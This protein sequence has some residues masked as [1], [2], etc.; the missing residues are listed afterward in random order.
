MKIFQKPV[1][2]QTDEND[3]VSSQVRTSYAHMDRDAVL[4]AFHSRGEGLSER[5]AYRRFDQYGPNAIAQEKRQSVLSR[6]WSNLTNPLVVMLALIGVVS[7]FTNDVRATVIIFVMLVIGVALRFFQELRADHAAEALRA[8]VRNTATVVRAGHE[9]EVALEFL[10]PGDVIRLSAGDM[11]PADVRILEAKDLFVNQSALTGESMPVEKKTLLETVLSSV[12]SNSLAL[13]NL[14][15]MGSNVVSGSAVAVVLVTGKNTYFGTLSAHITHARE[16]TSFDKGVDQLT[17]FIIRVIAVTV[18]L[19]FLINGWVRHDWV[20]AFLFALAVAVGLTPEML[21]MI[22]SVNLAKG[23]LKLAKKKI[24]V[25]RLNSIQNFGAMDVLCTDKTGTLTQGKIVLERHLDVN[26]DS[27][28]Q[29]LHYGY[30]NSYHHTGLKN[31]LDEAILDH[32]ELEER[33]KAKARYRKID[34]VPFDFVRRR[35]SVIV[36]DETGLNTLICKGAVEEIINQCN[37][38]EVN[39]RIEA[40]SDVCAEES[41]AL[42]NQLNADGFRVIALSYKQMPGASDALVYSV[43]DESDLILLGF[44]AFL[45]PPKETAAE[46]LQLLRGLDV[47]VKIL[48]GDNEIVTSYICR[49]VGIPVESVMLGPMIESMSD[50]ELAIAVKRTSVFARLAPLHKERI[51]R[52]LQVQGHVAGFLGDGI[53]DAPALKAADIGISVDS[54][55]DIAKESSDLIMLKTSLLTLEQGIREGRR[56]FGNVVKYVKMAVS[57]NFGNILSIVG[58]SAFLPFLPMLPIQILI[59]NLLYDFSQTAIPTDTIDQEW[60]AKPRKWEIGNIRWFVF[61]IGPISSIFDY[62]TFFILLYVFHCWTNPAMF[63]TG[64][65]LESVFSQTL[66]IHVIRTNQVPFLKSFASWP[67]TVVSVLMLFVATWLTKS[68]FAAS[69]GF[70]KMPSEFWWLLIGILVAYLSLTQLVKSW[71]VH[72]FGEG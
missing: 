57:S 38:V 41:R 46:A 54:A 47:D 29:V 28:D 53:N 56:V 3:H 64:W 22:V 65:F 30:L 9:R 24:I 27:S 16:K 42:V 6:L 61:L 59:N 2:N 68:S 39:G 20:E 70:V 15:F 7:F 69:L 4:K 36:E 18:P 60:L 52:S 71:F 49:E 1:R 11:I 32:E 33:L 55:V 45:D 44:L 19:V 13:S 40:M 10:V 50:D 72:R 12:E 48:T 25:K 5:E 37:R 31:L 23:A 62:V 43:Q 14:C 66:I 35:M 17:W 63:H 26:G 34:E 51:I 8:M 67:L 21:P 58:A